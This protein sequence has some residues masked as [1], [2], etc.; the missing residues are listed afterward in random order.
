MEYT[1]AVRKSVI[2]SSGVLRW[3]HVVQAGS[4]SCL[5]LPSAGLETWAATP[6]MQ[7][8]TGR[9]QGVKVKL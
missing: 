2:S 8:E 1:E 6:L 7:L 9:P 5:H 4:D 3:S